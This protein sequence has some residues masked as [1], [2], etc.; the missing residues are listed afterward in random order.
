MLYYYK[1]KEFETS[2]TIISE[3][4]TLARIENRIKNNTGFENIFFIR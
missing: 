4:I 2:S 3:S 1:W